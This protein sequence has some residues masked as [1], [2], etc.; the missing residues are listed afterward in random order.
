MTERRPRLNIGAVRS[1]F[2]PWADPAEVAHE[3]GIQLGQVG[4]GSV[5]T[6]VVAVGHNEFRSLR[7]AD[8]AALCRGDK[9]VL[10]DI[11]A[12][13]DRHAAA[14]AGFTVFRL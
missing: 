2:A 6:L 13:Y 3:Y 7:P 4:P 1:T 8:L 9:P 5:D 14:A 12:L 10:A 11:K